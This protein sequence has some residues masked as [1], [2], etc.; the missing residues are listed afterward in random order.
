[1]P[2]KFSVYTL[3]QFCDS[4]ENHIRG[5][6]ALGKKQDTYGDLLITAHILF[7]EGAQRSFITQSLADELE[8]SPEKSETLNLSVLAGL[9]L[10][11]NK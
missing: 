9:R 7:D 8:L 10:L 5:L 2:F 4:M 11:S 3:R 6:E 1:M